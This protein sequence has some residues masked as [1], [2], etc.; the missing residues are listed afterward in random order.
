MILNLKHLYVFKNKNRISFI[1]LN[2][3]LFE[4]VK[5]NVNLI[6]FI[7]LNAEILTLMLMI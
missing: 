1:N 4:I 3:F 7:I 6:N 2:L 5:K